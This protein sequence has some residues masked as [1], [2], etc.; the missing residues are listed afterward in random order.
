MSRGE[1]MARL[2]EERY[3]LQVP[4]SRTDVAAWERTIELCKISLEYQRGRLLNLELGKNYAANVWITSN[5]QLEY[6]QTE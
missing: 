1:A 5:K 3:K 4:Q 2:D 6:L